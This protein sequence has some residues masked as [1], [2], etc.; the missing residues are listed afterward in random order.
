VVRRINGDKIVWP[1]LDGGGGER[2]EGI[3]TVGH[4]TNVM[5]HK[6]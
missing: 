4:A 3:W 5:I 2:G 6:R 1:E